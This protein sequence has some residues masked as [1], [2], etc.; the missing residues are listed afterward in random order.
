MRKLITLTLATLVIAISAAGGQTVF[1]QSVYAG[2]AEL[3]FDEEK[4]ANSNEF[5]AS[6]GN[7][8]Y[9]DG[10]NGPFDGDRYDECGKFYYDAFL[11]GC[12]SIE[13]NTRDVCESATDG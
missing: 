9:D 7:A 11:E 3:D 2:G 10:Q 6:C 1:T 12:M 4:Y 8:G 13:G 5:R